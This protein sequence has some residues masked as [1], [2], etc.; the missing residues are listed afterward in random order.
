MVHHAIVRGH[1]FSVVGAEFPDPPFEFYEHVDDLLDLLKQA[2]LTFRFLL[3]AL[4]RVAPTLFQFP[5][6]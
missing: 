4:T 6:L 2:F 1:V 5:L 3:S